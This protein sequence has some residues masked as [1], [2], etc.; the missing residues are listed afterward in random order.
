M[1]DRELMLDRNCGRCIHFRNDA[2]FLE[3]AFS[4]LAVLS[5]AQGSVR[6]WDGICSLHGRYLSQRASCAK[7]E[8]LQPNH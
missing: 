2:S 8:P 4:G 6:G 1:T 5:S 3:E 7:F